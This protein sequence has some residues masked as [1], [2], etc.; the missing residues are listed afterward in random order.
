[1]ADA[2]AEMADPVDTTPLIEGS[3]GAEAK[4]DTKAGTP[5]NPVDAALDSTGKFF[6]GAGKSTGEFFTGAGKSTGEFFTGAG[7]SMGKSVAYFSF[8]W[9][10][11]SPLALGVSPTVP[12]VAVRFLT[13]DLGSAVCVG[14]VCGWVCVCVGVLGLRARFS[15]A[16]PLRPP[17]CAPGP[18][19]TPPPRR[20]L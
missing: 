5:T 12:W 19:L 4:A 11:I 13:V 16:T 9:D 1:M 20:P 3:D 8:G 6:T 10:E 7:E 18:I 14:C 15:P 2:A 17:V